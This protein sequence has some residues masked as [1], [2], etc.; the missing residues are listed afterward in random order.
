MKKVCLIM[1]VVMMG[2]VSLVSAQKPFAGTI[3]FHTHIE[4]TD[5][6]N[7]TSQGESEYSVQ[8]FGNYTKTVRSITDGFGMTSI[9]NGDAKNAVVILDIMGMG[10][11]YI[12]TTPEKIQEALK[13]TK[14]DYNKTGEKMTIA[15]YEC[16]KVIYTQTDLETDESREGVVYVSTAINNGD[17][18][19]FSELP[20]L[21]G[22]PMRTE[23]KQDIDG[24][25]V[26]IIV[27]AT[28]VIPSKK[29][30]AVDFMMPADAQDIKSNPELMKM[31]GMGGDEEDED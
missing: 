30:K 15:G 14:F 10:K 5:D 8:M 28:E 19:N 16:E 3:K 2:F 7:I 21:A 11:Y 22:F 18:I 31:L 27:E 1:A 29:I 23:V 13:N 9:T 6:P 20:G 12:E 25:E 24:T 26:T 17:A 4:G